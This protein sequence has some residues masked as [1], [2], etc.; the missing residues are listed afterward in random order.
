MQERRAFKYWITGPPEKTT[1]SSLWTAPGNSL[2]KISKL[3]T[4]KR[5]P[6]HHSEITLSRETEIR[7]WEQEGRLKHADWLEELKRYTM[8]T[9]LL[10]SWII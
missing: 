2:E 10:K 3:Q 6:K 8:I 4:K 1:E 5:E 7:V 9:L